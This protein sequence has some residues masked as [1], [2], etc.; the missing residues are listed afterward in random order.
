MWQH[1]AVE[2]QHLR[3]A[4]RITATLPEPL[5]VCFF[6]NSGSE[7]N[8]L[9]IRLVRA[10]TGAHDMVCVEHGYHGH[11]QTLIDV[12]PYKHAGRGACQSG[13]SR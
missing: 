1:L 9:A 7:A 5:S 6:V 12:S 13:G 4:E 8:E 10:A 11:S 2:H 3:Y